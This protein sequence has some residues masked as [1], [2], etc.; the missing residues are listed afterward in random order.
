[1]T[2]QSAHITSYWACGGVRTYA[3]QLPHIREHGT[4]DEAEEASG[5][6]LLAFVD[7]QGKEHS[8]PADKSE[9]WEAMLQTLESENIATVPYIIRGL[10]NKRVAPRSWKTLLK[11]IRKR[12]RAGLGLGGVLARQAGRHVRWGAL[13]LGVPDGARAVLLLGGAARRRARLLGHAVARRSVLDVRRRAA[14]GGRRR[15]SRAGAHRAHRPRSRGEA[16]Q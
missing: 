2:R 6:I 16:Q 10:E 8:V 5:V 15:A 1:M 14:H 7:L 12:F 3:T 4:D 11:V 13:G 9:T